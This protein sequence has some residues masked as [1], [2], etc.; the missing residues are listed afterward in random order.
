MT[1]LREGT[2]WSGRAGEATASEAIASPVE[3]LEKSLGGCGAGIWRVLNDFSGRKS[4]HRTMFLESSSLNNLRSGCA[5]GKR[6][7]C[8]LFLGSLADSS[9]E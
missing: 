7:K 5:C 4:A 6:D 8:L 1:G 9:L 3:P 2:L